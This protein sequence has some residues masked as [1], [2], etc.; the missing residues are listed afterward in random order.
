MSAAPLIGAVLETW[1]INHRIHLD[2]VA[3]IPAKGF[4]AVPLG[5]RGRDVAAQLTHTAQVRRGWITST[6][7]PRPSVSARSP[8]PAADITSMQTIQ[9]LRAWKYKRALNW[10]WIES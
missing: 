4:T 7:F 9:Y 8:S 10:K 1:R 6:I 2:L 5:S 3:G